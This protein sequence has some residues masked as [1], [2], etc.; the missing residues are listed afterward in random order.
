MQFWN[1]LRF[2]LQKLSNPR[3]RFICEFCGRTLVR[4][5]VFKLCPKYKGNNLNGSVTERG[6]PYFLILN[7]RFPDHIETCVKT[8]NLF[9]NIIY[10]KKNEEIFYLDWRFRA[11]LKEFV[12]RI[13]KWLECMMQHFSMF[14][15]SYAHP[16]YHFSPRLINK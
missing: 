14:L 6:C 11:N 3:I 15:C 4:N 5:Q 1:G 10:C 13:R 12:Q 7:K 2:H 16:P 8:N 9:R